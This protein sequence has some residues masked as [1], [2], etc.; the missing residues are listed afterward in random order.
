MLQS[1]DD[2]LQRV[3]SAPGPSPEWPDFFVD[4]FAVTGASISTLGP[5]LGSET[6]S[7]SDALAARLDEVQF[8][9]GEGPC[10]DAMR[11][12]SPV[13]A[14]DIR[15][16]RSRWPGFASTIA[17]EGVSSVFALPLRVGPLQIGAVDMYSA[18]RGTL[19]T[20]QTLRATVLATAVGQ[21]VLRAAMARSGEEGGGAASGAFSRRVIHQA[22]GM[23][24][25]QLDISADD[26]MLV[27]QGHAFAAGLTM[28]EVA[29]R[30][31]D[32]TLD[33]STE[34]GVDGE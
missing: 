18:E 8:D 16:S 6:I 13:F 31:V 27:L 12:A 11:T 7:A 15:E 19:D 22:T 26:A 4:L 32:R 28:M 17:E 20:D 14:H 3:R 30:V 33:F 1:F 24:L 10:W 9:L 34:D 23:V 25:A 5:L 2:T 21:Q 29:Q